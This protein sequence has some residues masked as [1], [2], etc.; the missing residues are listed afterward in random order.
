ML[1][2]IGGQLSVDLPLLIASTGLSSSDTALQRLGVVA[3]CSG[4]SGARQPWRWNQE[5]LLVRLVPLSAAG[6][7]VSPITLLPMLKLEF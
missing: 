7:I 1:S 3:P 2:G 6:A 5:T 4:R